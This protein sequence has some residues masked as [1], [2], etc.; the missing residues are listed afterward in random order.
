MIQHIKENKKYA[1]E[2]FHCF[3]HNWSI[4]IIVQDIG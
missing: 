2:K 1:Q 4:L 3:N